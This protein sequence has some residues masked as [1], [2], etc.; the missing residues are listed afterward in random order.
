MAGEMAAM[1][2]PAIQWTMQVK[3]GGGGGWRRGRRRGRRL[4][5]G[6]PEVLV[7]RRSRR[8]RRGSAGSTVFAA[9]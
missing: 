8:G 5:E 1:D 2:G 9:R 3:T 6:G 7:P 4:A